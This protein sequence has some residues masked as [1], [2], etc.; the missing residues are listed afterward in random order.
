MSRTQIRVSFG[1]AVGLD[2]GAVWLVAKVIGVEI[3]DW[4]L[5]MLQALEDDML[6]E[7][8]ERLRKMEKGRH[9]ERQS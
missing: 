8:A 5:M 7:Q 2:Y 9:E 3:D 6:K 1:G 4:T